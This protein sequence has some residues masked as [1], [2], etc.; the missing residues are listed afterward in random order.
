[1]ENETLI[2][3][4][5]SCKLSPLNAWVRTLKDFDDDVAIIGEALLREYDKS[6]QQILDIIRRDIG[7]IKLTVNQWH[8]PATEAILSGWPGFFFRKSSIGA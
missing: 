4:L 1:M 5:L 7:D 8:D 2:G 3:D 6:Q